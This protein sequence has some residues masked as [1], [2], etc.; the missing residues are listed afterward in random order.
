MDSTAPASHLLHHLLGSFTFVVLFIILA[1]PPDLYPETHVFWYKCIQNNYTVQDSP[2]PNLPQ[3]IIRHEGK[4]M[5]ATLNQ[6]NNSQEASFVFGSGLDD[7]QGRCGV[8]WSKDLCEASGTAKSAKVRAEHRDGWS[9]GGFTNPG[10]PIHVRLGVVD[11]QG[12]IDAHGSPD[13]VPET[14]TWADGSYPLAINMG[15]NAQYPTDLMEE[16]TLTVIAP[17]GKQSEFDDAHLDK[18]FFEA[19]ITDQVN[20]ILGR[21]GVNKGSSSGQYAIVFLMATGQGSIGKIN[22]YSAENCVQPAGG[23]APW[24]R[25]GNTLHVVVE[26]DNLSFVSTEQQDLSAN[27]GSVVGIICPNPCQGVASFT[28]NTG[29]SKNGIVRVYSPDGRVAFTKSVNGQGRLIW[30]AGHQAIGLY[31]CTLSAAGRSHSRSMVVL[32]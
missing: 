27:P 26:S 29:H 2:G 5:S 23:D 28:F 7:A 30:D 12:N 11:F 4:M 19:D 3:N 22:T 21:T 14:A 24:N 13:Y 10:G 6:R 32:R 15:F 20:W 18:I 1:F 17:K 25:D 9:G 31:V 8:F 16:E